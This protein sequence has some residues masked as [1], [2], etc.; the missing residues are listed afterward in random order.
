M[1]NALAGLFG[2]TVSTSFWDVLVALPAAFVFGQLLAWLYE[3]TFA[4]ISYSRRFADMLTLLSCVSAMFVLL[5]RQSLTAGLGFMAIV[6]L[7]RFR[8][9]VKAPT[10]LIFIMA[11]AT[12]GLGSGLHAFVVT[13]VGFLAFAAFALF[14]SSESLGSRRRFD[15]V[16]RLR[17]EVAKSNPV[18]VE[19][20]V[21]RHCSRSVLLSSTELAQ[22]EFVELSYQVKFKGPDF[23][24]AMMQE[25][26]T[27]PGVRDARLL[28]QEVALEY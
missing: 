22:G 6:T 13:G 11:A 4:G 28:L 1:P 19:A 21:L 14:L 18:A 2:S 5:A 7:V 24:H 27:A 26:L 25:L 8:A 3:A 17:C 20:M 12:F 10:D 9:N 15:G 16:L 23:R